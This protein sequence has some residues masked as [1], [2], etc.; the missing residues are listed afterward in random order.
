M[1]RSTR[2]LAIG[3]TVLVAALVVMLV[4]LRDQPDAIVVADDAAATTDVAAADTDDPQTPAGT[5]GALAEDGER[6][7]APLEVP[8]G[9]E[10]VAVSTN[11]DAAVAALPVPGDTVNVYG[12]FQQGLPEQLGEAPDTTADGDLLRANAKGVVR[13]LSGVEVLGVSGVE[14]ASGAGNVTLVL[15][16]APIDAERTIY[17]AAT[18]QVWFSLVASDH[19]PTDGRGVTR[20]TVLDD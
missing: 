4:A 8:A 14:P 12:V 2:L 16:L 18:E 17:L 7:P 6:L 9:F 1:T 20:D 3:V 10:A 11:Y 15:A 13:V 5:V 19:E